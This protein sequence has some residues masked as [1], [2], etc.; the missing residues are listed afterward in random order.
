[1]EIGI[2]FRNKT[3]KHVNNTDED[4]WFAS[5]NNISNIHDHLNR[6]SFQ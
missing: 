2:S 5:S 1:M 4:I 3:W 6:D